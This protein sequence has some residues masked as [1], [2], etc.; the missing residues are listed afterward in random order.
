MQQS[1]VRA[2]LIAVI[3]FNICALLVR[4]YLQIELGE[5]GYHVNFAKDL[6]YLI[7]PPILALLLWPVVRRNRHA[8]LRCFDIHRLTMRLVLNA[9]GIGLLARAA[10]WCAL[11]FSVA[12]GIA[13]NAN[14]AAIEGP[15]F[16]FGCPP[17]HEFALALLVW[18]LLIPISEE[19]VHRGLI[20]SS[21]MPRGR[22]T[23][24]I[25]SALIFMAFHRPAAMP[26]AL[27]LGIVMA[28][29][30]VESGTLWAPI[31]THAAYDGLTQLDWRCL[32]GVWNPLPAD[33][34]LM[35]PAIGSLC[36]LVATI[37]GIAWLLAKTG[38][39][40]APRSHPA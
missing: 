7:V 17:A 20:Q 11:V 12:T 31:I 30:F 35:A 21:L 23:A 3:I 24:I 25:L 16:R 22:H 37:G 10:F 1:S 38:A 9:V 39:R 40:R 18:I 26:V 33:T 13:T 19:V 6:S 8:L 4:A 14:P 15:V 29:Q 34:P 32:Q 5:R 2:P 28:I 36:G 27:L